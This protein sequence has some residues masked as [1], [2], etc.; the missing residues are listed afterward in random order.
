[1][2]EFRYDMREMPDGSWCV[3]DVFTGLIAKVNDAYITDL[4]IQEADDMVD[5]LNQLYAE[6]YS[7][8]LH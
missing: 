8:P 7:G 6:R 2:T 4:D 5:L 3:F 1:M